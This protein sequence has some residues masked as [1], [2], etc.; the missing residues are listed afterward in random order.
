L[1]LKNT[2]WDTRCTFSPTF[3]AYFTDDHLHLPLIEWAALAGVEEEPAL[4]WM[5][6]NI[7]PMGEPCV[8][9]DG[10][11]KA[12]GQRWIVAFPVTHLHRVA[13][14]GLEAV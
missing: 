13:E 5:A 12:E 7:N 3:T 6:M 11:D 9:G 1:I 2:K 8:R 14:L 4:V 10:L